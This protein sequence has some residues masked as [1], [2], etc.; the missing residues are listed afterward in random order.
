[1]KI[2]FI[3]NY[4]INFGGEDYMFN[5]EVENMKR[6][7]IDLVVYQ[8]SNSDIEK[9][10]LFEK[11]NLLVNYSFNKKTFKNVTEIIKKEKIDL[12]HCFNLIHL[13]SPSVYYACKENNIPIVQSLHNYRPLCVNG[14]FFRNDRICFECLQ[15]PLINSVE[16]QCYRNSKLQTLLLAN[17][18]L[19][20][21][22]AY[23][24]LV[25]AY[26]APSQFVKSIFFQAGYQ[27]NKIFVRKNFLIENPTKSEVDENYFLFVG[28][29]EKAKG[30]N[31]LIDAAKEL[32]D[33]KF[34]A[35]GNNSDLK[36]PLPS[37][38][39]AIGELPRKNILDWIARST[40]VVVPSIS[41]E[42]FSITALDA[43]AF[44]KPIIVSKIGGLQE[45]C[46][47][48][49]NGFFIEPGNLSQL[50]KKIQIIHKDVK[51][52]QKMGNIGRAIFEKEYSAE[53]AFLNISLIYQNLLNKQKSNKKETIDAIRQFA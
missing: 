23:K 27:E 9:L 53:S 19:E 16:K 2:L 29:L 49:T 35:I 3:H 22:D 30:I 48:E 4:Y 17:S 5:A 13:I 31:I 33:I 25:D 45:L 32:P 1:M 38:F 26:I 18:I 51:L 34:V 52:R 37:N 42:T 47:E 46:R 7:N 50:I 40:A 36:K 43:M 15:E 14:K 44:G 24:H 6:H 39:N 41:L 8:K 20:N 10:S 21:E 12:C 11:A 28:R